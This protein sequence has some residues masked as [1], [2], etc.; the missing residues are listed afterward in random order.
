MSKQSYIKSFYKPKSAD[1]LEIDQLKSAQLSRASRA[2]AIETARS[3]KSIATSIR[4]SIIDLS[5]QSNVSSL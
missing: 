2:T 4:S 3:C 1:E 5:S